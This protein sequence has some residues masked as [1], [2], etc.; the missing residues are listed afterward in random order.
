MEIPTNLF[1]EGT[2]CEKERDGAH[3]SPRAEPYFSHACSFYAVDNLGASV[4]IRCLAEVTHI[5]EV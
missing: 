3:L 2:R 4:C 5:R 1:K